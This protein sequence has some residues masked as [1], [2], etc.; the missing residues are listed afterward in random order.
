MITKRRKFSRPLGQRSYRKLF[1][2]AVE[3]VKTEH[4]YFSLFNTQN[5]VVRVSCIKGKNSDSPP[6]ILKRLKQKIADEALRKNDEAWVVV[7]KDA[8]MDKQL[9]ELWNWSEE[10]ENYGLAL[11]NPKFEFWLLLHFEDGYKA[12]TSRACSERLNKYLPGYDKGFDVRKVSWVMVAE[13]VE[14][15][16]QRDMPACVD[17]PRN[18]GVTTVY[19]LVERFL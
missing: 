7:D 6:A 9:A 2:L 1:I 15:G 19:R 14:R 13:A 5:S 12:T 18:E 4:T 3:G 16:R 17:W 11:S 8:W 10:R